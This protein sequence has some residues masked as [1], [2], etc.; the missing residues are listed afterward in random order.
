MSFRV[1]SK[2]WFLAIIL[3]LLTALGIAPAVAADDWCEADPIVRLDGTTT[4]QILVSIPAQHLAGVTSATRVEVKTPTG[5]GRELLYTDAGFN[6]YGEQ[7]AFADL[8]NGVATAQGYLVYIRVEVPMQTTI[9]VVIRVRIIPDN[10][11]ETVI[12]GLH[13]GTATYLWLNR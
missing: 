3:A 2:R 6:G 13:T 12:Y 10:G 9:P 11:P 4:V 1:A 7:V 5:I 8:P